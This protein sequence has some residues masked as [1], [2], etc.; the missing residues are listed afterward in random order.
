LVR[1][2]KLGGHP[3][4]QRLAAFCLC[5]LLTRHSGFAQKE[6]ESADKNEAEMTSR[7]AP[8]TFN[9]RV[10]LVLVPVV[11]RDS[12][13]RAIGNLQKEDF[14]LF[15]KGK[16]QVIMKF[17]IEKSS[18]TPSKDTGGTTSKTSET[19]PGEPA[20]PALPERYT[21][22][23]FDD[24]HMAFGDLARVREAADRHMGS[25]DATARS[26]IYS[27]S[28]QTTL[29]FTDDRDKLHETLLQLKPRP[30][31]SQPRGTGCPD[32]SLYQADL[33]QNKN[34]QQA[35]LVATRDAMLCMHLDPSQIALAQ[36]SAR[37]TASQV[38]SNGEHESRLALTVLRDVVRRLSAMPGQRAVVL[39]SPGF[40]TT[41][42]LMQ[43]RTDVIGRAIRANVLISALDARGLYTVIPGADASQRGE[44]PSVATYKAQYESA[45][46]M[47]E[48]D[49]LAELADGTGGTFFQNSNDLVVGFKHVAVAPDYY[50]VL[51]YSPENLKLDGSFHRLKVTLKEGGKFSLQARRGYYAPRHATDPA[52]MAKQEI[53]EALFSRE[54]MHDI[55]VELHTQFF[56]AS[57]DSARVAVVARVDVRHV[58]FRKVDGR[59]RNDLTVVSALFDRNGTY[60]AGNEKI[61]EMRLRDE[62]LEKRLGSGI[63]VR[64]SFD[65]RPGTYMVRL[66]V[67]DAEGQMMAAQNGAV[68]IQ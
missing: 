52:E 33:I 36:A 61:L 26:A 35:F 4:M 68:E 48:A 41:F 49:I 53:Q 32:E 22:Y 62:T 37:S 67:R 58:H 21:A 39:V 3:G 10:N 9:A 1:D 51:G 38:L 31:S 47:Q 5:A 66:V 28:G 57:V 27:I 23:L 2:H 50:Y 42:D 12:Q 15:D 56:K 14:Q 7:E 19:T 59:N 44:D 30:I 25:L 60:I 13:G 54:E 6:A 11:V 18:G 34:D 20:P 16:A 64:T 65:V 45:G 55:P 63:T 24:V 46:A 17:S 43:D 8:A 40:L 29:D